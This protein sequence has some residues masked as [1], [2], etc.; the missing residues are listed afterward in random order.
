MPTITYDADNRHPRLFTGP[1]VEFSRNRTWPEPEP[2]AARDTYP[3]PHNSMIY[4]FADLLG[5]GV[6]HTVV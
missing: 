3:F 2:G 5:K 6:G 1:E 4:M